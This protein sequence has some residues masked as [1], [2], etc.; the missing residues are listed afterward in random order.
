MLDERGQLLSESC[1]VLLV[2]VDL[3]RRAS[4]LE[5]HSLIGRSSVEIIFQL[6]SYLCRHRDLQVR[7]PV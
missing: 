2:Q 1:R 7:H 4:E 3:V 6:N 5:L